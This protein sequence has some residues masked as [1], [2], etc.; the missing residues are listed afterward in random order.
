VSVLVL[1]LLAVLAA[2]CG[3]DSRRPPPAAGTPEPTREPGAGGGAAEAAPTD[4]ARTADAPREAAEI[5]ALVHARLRALDAGRPGAYAATATGARRGR[6]AAD[7][8]RAR[9]LGVRSV[10]RDA[11]GVDAGRERARARLRV[12]YRLHGVPGRWT[13]AEGLRLRRTREGWRVS[14]ARAR[15][16]RPP[17]QLA[18][19][20]R[21]RTRHFTVFAP[22]GVDTGDAALGDALERAYATIRARLPGRAER[23]YPVFVA[24]NFDDMA[25]MTRG[26]GDVARLSAITD[27]SLRTSGPAE[28]VTAVLGARILIPWPSFLALAPAARERVL[29]HELAH[30]ILAPATSGRAPAWLQEGI[31]LYVSGDRRT[32]TAAASLRAPGTAAPPRLGRLALPGA[33]A[34]LG[35]RDLRHAYALSSSAAYYIAE[36]FGEKDLLAL[37]AVFS[38]ESLT[39]RE[40]RA[41]VDRAT[42]RVL[43]IGVRRLERDVSA[44]VRAGAPEAGG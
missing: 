34:T 1:A 10:R 22:E 21:L 28:R 13:Y 25:A 44:W 39:G 18:T 26:T 32:A 17:W 9:R 16:P 15:R 31:A 3:G 4:A 2:G 14:G 43:G 5:V 42:R 20:R 12:S 38:D 29:I 36:T 8:R 19:H 11:L 35:A 24:A 41:L 40:G 37:L 30:A 6:D 33:M 27:L 23:R 7:A